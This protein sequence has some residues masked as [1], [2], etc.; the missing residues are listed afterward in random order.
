MIFNI[1]KKRHTNVVFPLVSMIA[2]IIS[3]IQM[4]QI[5]KR[6]VTHEFNH[7]K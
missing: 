7:S 6:G 2:V 4:N 1:V 5:N 3:M